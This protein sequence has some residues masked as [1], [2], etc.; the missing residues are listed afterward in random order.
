MAKIAPIAVAILLALA[1]TSDARSFNKKDEVER[2]GGV[3]LYR[4]KDNRVEYLLLKKAK[5][6]DWSPPK[7]NLAF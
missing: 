7:G 3:I 4:M 2:I 6:D 5:E 1:F